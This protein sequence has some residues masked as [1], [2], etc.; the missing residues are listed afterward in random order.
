MSC[1]EPNPPTVTTGCAPGP[2]DTQRA[3][4]YETLVER[5]GPHP[6]CR[7]TCDRCAYGR[8][9]RRIPKLSEAS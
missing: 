8:G 7:C 4:A 3:A 9:W 2:Y 1:A 5:T 6:D